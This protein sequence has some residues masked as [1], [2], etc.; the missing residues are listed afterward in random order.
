MTSNTSNQP[1]ISEKTADKSDTN[2]P[3]FKPH[4]T[5]KEI[6]DVAETLR[7]G[8]LTSGPQVKEFER[9]F[10]EAVKADFA[11][12]LNSCTAA[13][14]LAVEALGLQPGQAVLVP[15]MTFAATAEI[16]LYKNAIPILVD[17]EPITG[18]MDLADAE[19]KLARLKS[20]DLPVSTGLDIEAVG[21]IPVHVGGYM[22]DIANVRDFA[23]KHKLWVVEDAA[24]AFP[25]AWRM[26]ADSDWQFCGENTADVTCYSFYA[27]KTMTTGEGGMA[28]TNDS[29]L[30]DRMRL[31]SLHGLSHDAWGRYSGGAWDYRI[32]APGYKYN[33]TDIAAALGRGQLARAE[34]MRQQRESIAGFYL[35][36][37][38]GGE[39]EL[40]PVSDDRL[41]S[42][43]LFP[44]RLN[45]ESLTIDRD[46][47]MVELK[48]RG[49]GCSVHWRPLQLHPLYEG[50]GWRE[51]DLPVSSEVWE[52]LI[53]LPISSSMSM[54]QA[55]KVVDTV[56]QI[57]A[58]NSKGA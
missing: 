48:E 13:L 20:G 41:H 51:S 50:L 5:E 34:E 32:V 30:A 18:N 56:K 12:A 15:A 33:L 16:V 42:W 49:V 39:I 46:Q 24:H 40:P 47:F 54:D 22:L 38:A 4:L 53:S 45:L 7:S 44:I 19:A 25:A 57:C 11:I 29:E 1:S 10:A 31:M 3:F 14:H 36:S 9:E 2:V 27:N 43:H 6:N 8:W 58:E 26:G 52:R 23:D 28:V 21:I 37:F 17:C 55:I 35:D